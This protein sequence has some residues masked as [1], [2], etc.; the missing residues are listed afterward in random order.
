[1]TVNASEASAPYSDGEARRLASSTSSR[2]VL[3]HPLVNT[4]GSAGSVA[5]ASGSS[6]R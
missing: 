3:G 4:M 2:A 6:R 5:P 1:M